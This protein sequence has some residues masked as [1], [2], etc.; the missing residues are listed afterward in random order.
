VLRYHAGPL[1]QNPGCGFNTDRGGRYA[2]GPS[3]L[4]YLITADAKLTA[5]KLRICCVDRLLTPLLR[6]QDPSVQKVRISAAAQRGVG[7]E[8]SGDRSNSAVRCRREWC[9]AAGLDCSKQRRFTFHTKSVDG[10]VAQFLDTGS[11]FLAQRLEFGV[12]DL[13]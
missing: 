10:G 11:H 2:I 12:A 5:G 9:L 13:H 6:Y 7:D 3:I 1:G 4:R 8:P